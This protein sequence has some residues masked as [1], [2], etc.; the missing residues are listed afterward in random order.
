MQVLITGGTGFLGGVVVDRF[1]RAGLAPII[2]LL[3]EE[4]DLPLPPGI[5]RRIVPP[6]SA[7]ADYREAL[8]GVD[9]VVH[10]AARVH[11][12]RD[13]AKDPLQEFRRVN[14]HG[15][16]C[17]ARQAAQAGVRRFVFVSTV[18]VLGEESDTPYREDSP[19]NPLDPYGVSKAE[20]EGALSS[21]AASGGMELVIVRPPLV[22]GPG[23]KAN[24]RQ[25]LG[26]VSRG[27]PLPLASIRNSR[28]LVFVGNLADALFC[29]ATHPAAAGRTFLVSDGEDLST[30]LLVRLIAE[31]LGRPARLF[32]I[33][34][35]MLAIAGKLTGRNSAVERLAG[36]LR[37][38][39]SGIRRE[40]NWTPPYTVEEGMRITADWFKSL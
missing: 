7:T 40:L 26:L 37:V 15:S 6:L 34:T 11:V 23:V 18:K 29:C 10:L 39:S 5:G 30:P 22:Y 8:Q 35:A 16:E 31:S 1:L 17:L 27:I 21:I 32:P 2:A 28:S 36:S 20:A 3:E 9:I 24:F 25:L 14:L 38:D 13:T 19:L 33:P 4:R 12:M